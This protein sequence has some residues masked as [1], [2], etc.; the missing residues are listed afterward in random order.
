VLKTR[1][2]RD[3]SWKPAINRVDQET[4]VDL[5]HQLGKLEKSQHALNE[6]H[7]E[8]LLGR[9]PNRRDPQLLREALDELPDLIERFRDA[10]DRLDRMGPLRSEQAEKQRTAA[11]DYFRKRADLLELIQRYLKDKMNWRNQEAR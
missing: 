10:G 3:P 9:H 6:S 7:L 11:L 5:G 8:E 4:L 2:D 1:S